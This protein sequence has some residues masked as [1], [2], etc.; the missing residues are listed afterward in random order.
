MVKASASRAEDPGFESRLRR[1][2]FGVKIGTPVA[3]LP[4][5]W[6]YRV[7]ARTGWHGV[8]ILWPGEMESLVCNFYLIVAARKIEQI[9]PWDT[10]ACCWDVKQPTNKQPFFCFRFFVFLSFSFF[11]L[12]NFPPII[13]KSHSLLSL[14]SKI[15][16]PSG[17]WRSRHESSYRL[18]ILKATTTA[19][20]RKHHL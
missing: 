17:T 8:S 19:T 20:M 18:Q 2:F 13:L 4:D 12:I 14:V 7:S 6:C 5:A 10:L 15:K 11:L 3:T 1:D 16:L 9:C